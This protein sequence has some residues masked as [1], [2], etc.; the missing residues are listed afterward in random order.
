[1]QGSPGDMALYFL[2]F[3]IFIIFSKNKLNN[4]KYLKTEGVEEK[5]WMSTHIFGVSLFPTKG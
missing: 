4:N 3:L 2:R 1:V 5:K